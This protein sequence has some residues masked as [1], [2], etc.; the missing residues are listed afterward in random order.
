MSL[1][2]LTG[3]YKKQ[4]AIGKDEFFNVEIRA[5]NPKDAMNN[6]REIF[7]NTGYEH[8]LFQRCFKRFP[9]WSQFGGYDWVEI[10]MIQAL[11]LE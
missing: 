4:N 7:Y 5:E 9:S 3:T 10:P 11:G 8:I 2:K 6:Q 1:Y